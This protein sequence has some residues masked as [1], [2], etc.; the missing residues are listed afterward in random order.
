MSDV[1]GLLGAAHG[2]DALPVELLSRLELAWVLDV[3]ARDLLQE[4]VDS[5]GG[6]EHVPARDPHWWNRYPGW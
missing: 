4:Y 3:L 1:P 2:V 5:P 6:S